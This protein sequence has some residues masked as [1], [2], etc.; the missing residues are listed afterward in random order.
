MWTQIAPSFAET[1]TLSNAHFI[2]DRSTIL[3][4]G[5][6]SILASSK[7]SDC[8]V[9]AMRMECIGAEFGFNSS[10]LYVALLAQSR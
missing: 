1:K 8:L 5:I 2:W 9:G 6:F 4:A 3:S 10:M 7:F